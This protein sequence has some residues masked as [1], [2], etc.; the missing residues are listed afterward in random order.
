MDQ[1]RVQL[2]RRLE[3]INEPVALPT[4]QTMDMGLEYIAASSKGGNTTLGR[5]GA[6]PAYGPFTMHA[7]DLQILKDAARQVISEASLERMEIGYI[8]AEAK[9]MFSYIGMKESEIQAFQNAFIKAILDAECAPGEKLYVY[10][11]KYESDLPLFF[12]TRNSLI[13]YFMSLENLVPWDKMSTDDL[14]MWCETIDEVPS[15][16]RFVLLTGSRPRECFGSV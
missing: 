8:W 3:S 16:S 15:N 11:H 13:D 5:Y 6:W 9:E 12:K 1:D 2:L 10:F 4:A 7:E 14:G